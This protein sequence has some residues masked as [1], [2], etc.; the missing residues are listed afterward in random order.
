MLNSNFRISLCWDFD[1][2]S[3]K[4]PQPQHVKELYVFWAILALSSTSLRTHFL[5]PNRV[6]VEEFL[7]ISP[8]MRIH[9]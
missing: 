7:D 5:N 2:L 3:L 1:N 4:G 9:D 6:V 8:D